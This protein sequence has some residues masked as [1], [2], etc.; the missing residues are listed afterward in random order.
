MT[1]IHDFRPFEERYLQWEERFRIG[2]GLGNYSF[3]PG[4]RPCPYGPCDMVI[5]RATLGLLDFSEKEKDA[6]AESINAFQN[7]A[8]WYRKS[9]TLHFRDHTTAYAVA[10]LKLL[11]RRSGQTVR[12]AAA[13]MES[14][15]KTEAWLRGAPWSLIWPGSHI[16][17]G[18]PAVLHMTGVGTDDFFDWYFAWLD[19]HVDGETGFWSRGWAQRLGL[20]P[21]LSKEA[22]GGAFHMHYLYEARGRP[23]PH[24]RGVV[25]S[26]LSLQNSAGLWD[27]D[28][29]YCIDLDGV[30]SM[31]RCSAAAG[32]YRKDDAVAACHRFLST[33]AAVLNDP[34][35]LFADYP[36]SH[37]LPGALSAVAEVARSFPDLVITERPWKQTLDRACYI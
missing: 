33:T 7:S 16:V 20:I 18:L 3:L 17:T 34:V 6:W 10:A 4:G 11:D 9:Y 13:L 14:R 26:C 28:V 15:A 23:I 22:M 8:G 31:L 25:D 21:K 12:A 5:A 24:P 29:P 19:A 35:R 36:N 37:R 30:Y 32:W 27:K 2:D 1:Q